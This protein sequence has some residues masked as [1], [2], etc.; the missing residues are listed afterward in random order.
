MRACLVGMS[1]RQKDIIFEP[2]TW[3]SRFAGRGEKEWILNN[4]IYYIRL[5][6]ED[7][8]EAYILSLL[9]DNLIIWTW[10]VKL[11]NMLV[12]N[13][14]S[15]KVMKLLQEFG[16]PQMIDMNTISIWFCNS[17]S[18]TSLF[19]NWF[20]HNT[21]NHYFP[22]LLLSTWK[23]F[24]MPISI[25]RIEKERKTW[26][27]EMRS[28]SLTSDLINFSMRNKDKKLV[29]SQGNGSAVNE[30]AQQA[31]GSKFGPLEN[32]LKFKVGMAVCL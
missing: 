21:S 26:K 14:I 7:D 32:S 23:F 3:N 9:A 28:V 4:G 17:C 16:T 19:L 22:F 29:N 15:H 18:R 30:H 5:S 1:M 6:T 10:L 24:S 13:L 12:A 8:R 31:R 25:F 20:C 27:S 2:S 11:G